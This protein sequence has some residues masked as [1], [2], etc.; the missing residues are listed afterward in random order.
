MRPLLICSALSVQLFVVV[1]ASAQ[2]PS[3]SA[4]ATGEALRVP[5]A[6]PGSEAPGLSTAPVAVDEAAPSSAPVE[7]GAVPPAEETAPSAATPAPGGSA[8]NP[9]EARAALPV[10]DNEAHVSASPA[11]VPSDAASSAPK[12]PIAELKPTEANLAGSKPAEF[13]LEVPATRQGHFLAFGLYGVGAMGFDASRGTRAPTLGEGFSLRLGESV[14]SWLDLSL[15]FAFAGT[16]G[17][18]K[19][20]FS[21]G[22]LG[23]QSQWYFRPNWFGQF[24]FGGTNASGGDPEDPEVNRVRYGAAFWTGIGVNIP[25]SNAH[26]SG[27]WILT[28]VATFEIA[29]EKTLT[30]TALWLGLEISWWSGLAKD[31]LAL[32]TAEAYRKTAR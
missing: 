27:G 17:E 11:V 19:D 8:S 28:P 10:P 2:E 29:P 4:P 25:L 26:K 23:I 31:K 13:H 14:T 18:A 5:E 9:V 3:P 22:R 15:A 1:N 7:A 32:P 16:Q 12:P 30:T 6:P 24:G 20:R 21:F